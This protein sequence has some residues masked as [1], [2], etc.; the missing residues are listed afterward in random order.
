MLVKFVGVKL[1][2]FG[3]STA[4]A[5]ALAVGASL[6]AATPVMAKEAPPAKATNSPEFSKAAGPFQKLLIDLD[7]QKTKIT[8]DDLK[9]KAVALEPQLETVEASVKTPLDRI[10]FAQWQY[11]LGNMA[12]DPALSTKGLQNMLASGQLPAD[13]ALLVSTQLGKNA[14]NA[15]DYA[16]A[17]KALTPLITN[18]AVEDDVPEVLAVSYEMSGQPKQGLESLKTAIATRKTATGSAP[19]DWY[20][21]GKVI[22]Y[23]AKLPAESMEWANLVVGAYPT[24]LNWI[25]AAEITLFFEQNFASQ[26]ELDI[27]RLMDQSGAL[28]LEP[29]LA[30]R[31]YVAYV[32]LLDARLYPGETVRI[33]EQGIAHGALRA[34]DTFVKD[35]LSQARAR[36]NE[37]KNSLPAL[38]KDAAASP[39]GKVAQVAGDTYLSFGQADKADEMFTLAVSKGVVEADNDRLLTRLG[40]A[41]IDE[42]KYADAKATLAKVG[43]VRKSIAQ[44]WTIYADQKAAG[45]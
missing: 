15:K 23:N 45:K 30:D 42:G 32:Q 18:P 1:S 37:V 27:Y 7:G 29:K 5:I 16:G 33:A 35:A 9:A 38:A 21:R 26:D 11:T 28:N 19:A 36:L 44:L 43:G 24:P 8:P 40:I 3:R 6:V 20:N 41:Q 25:G 13:K 17:I 14:Y 34:D 10:I 12:G 22:A 31:K 4:A 39:K 2:S